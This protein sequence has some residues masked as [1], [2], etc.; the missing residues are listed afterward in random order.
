MQLWDW[1][2]DDPRVAGFSPFHWDDE[3]STTVTLSR[4]NLFV[5]IP[6]TPK[7]PGI[8]IAGF[9]PQ[10]QTGFRNM[11]QT[12]SAWV[13]IGTKILEN[14]RAAAMK[15]DDTQPTDAVDIRGSLDGING[16]RPHC[17]PLCESPPGPITAGGWAV[18]Y[19]LDGGRTP[20]NVSISVD[21]TI[22]AT[23]L[24]DKPRPDLVPGHVAPDPNHGFSIK[25]PPAVAK[26]MLM[27]GQHK[28]Y[29]VTA[30]VGDHALGD[31]HDCAA[32]ACKAAPPP[33]RLEYVQLGSFKV[34]IDMSRGGSIAYMSS[35]ATGGA[36]VVNSHDM[37]REIQLSFYSGPTFYNPPTAAYPNGACDKLFGKNVSWPWNPT[38][39]GKCSRSLC[40]SY[41][42]LKDAAAQTWTTTMALSFRSP[43]PQTRGTFCRGRCNGPVTT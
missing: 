26:R 28:R 3:P 22:V 33:D 36:N 37:G 27:P 25:L 41:R 1:A 24:A 29:N 40:V 35:A 30:L 20:V 12:L 19:R 18:D 15:S 21:G 31:A 23:A 2:L 42:G 17:S 5:S 4:F 16:A 8:T 43:R 39:G 6:L 9:P 32:L 34:G 7:V 13:E 14:A 38:G 10:M 11:P